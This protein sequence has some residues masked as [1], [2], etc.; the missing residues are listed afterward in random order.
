MVAERLGILNCQN[1]ERFEVDARLK[2]QN[3]VC[4]DVDRFLGVAFCVAKG[5][6]YTNPVRDSSRESSVIAS[7]DEQTEHPE[8]QDT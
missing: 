7:V 2:P 6:C 8:L 1:H 4:R 5:L 3:G